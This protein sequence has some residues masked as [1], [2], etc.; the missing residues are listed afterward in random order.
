MPAHD[1]PFPI[2]KRVPLA[3]IDAAVCARL[4]PARVRGNA[5][6][7]AFNRQIA[8]YLAKHVG[9]WSATSI[10][11]FYNGRDHST[12]CHAIRRVESMREQNHELDALLSGMGHELREQ[13]PEVHRAVDSVSGRKT[14]ADWANEEFLEIVVDRIVD[15]LFERIGKGPLA[16]APELLQE[17]P[18]NGLSR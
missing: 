7:A 6:P 5:Q 8:M 1:R 9:G 16:G 14:P 18:T 11:K 17:T 13:S 3:V 10:G 2:A 12:V 15:R 4:G